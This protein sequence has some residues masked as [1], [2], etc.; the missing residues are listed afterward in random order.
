MNYHL[1]SLGW[2]L[3]HFCWQAGAIAVV[4]WLADA[5]LSKASSQTRY[6]LAL[7]AMLLMFL[8][9]VATFGYE[10][11][12]AHSKPF[13]SDAGSWAGPS[14]AFDPAS[15][16][17]RST[18]G[19][20]AEPIRLSQLLPWLDVAWSL[21]VACFSTRTIAGWGSLQR[22]RKQASVEAPEGVRVNFT[23][24]CHRLGIQRRVDLLIS[25][26][27]Q[28]PLAMGIVRAV[29]LV[30]ASTLMALSPEQL[31]AVL[32]HELAHIRR[33]D[34]VWNLAQT[35]IET[36]FFFHPA[37]WW[38]G[39]KV[40]HHRELCCDDLAVQSCGDAVL[41]ATALL[42]LEEQRS[43]QL[44]LAM[45][46]DGH[47]SVSGLRTRIARILGESMGNR[48]PH[49][50]APLPLAAIFSALTL[51]LLSAPPLL[52]G[53]PQNATMT[54]AAPALPPP[55]PVRPVPD[56]VVL[57]PTPR[58]AVAPPAARLAPLAA[59]GIQQSATA[60]SPAHKSDYIDEMRAAGY[61]ADIDKYVAMKVQGITPDYA[62]EMAKAGFGKPSADDLIA[63]KVQGVT[64]DY[65]AELHSAGIEPS[66]FG[67]LVAYRIFHVTPEFFAGM[68][69]AGFDSVP[70]SKLIALRV[71][72]VTPEYA[73]TVKQQY[74]NAT[75]DELVQLRIFH[76][77]DAF[78]AA[79]KRHGFTS[80]S[81]EKLVQLRI[82]GVLGDDEAG[83]K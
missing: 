70:P 44:N 36:L 8:G 56:P 55:T 15:F 48:G 65:V 63:M 80:L 50:P 73:K 71:H 9:A 69:A 57:P 19:S 53:L 24:L 45:A 49:E 81:I 78:L 42:R 31:E 14:A 59:L 51:L 38:L 2:T 28:G 61:D 34:Y 54:P 43:R 1:Q 68:K 39:H 5:A 25:E 30:P 20:A 17:G 67:D 60:D 62:R 58:I 12:H 52:A 3:L 74:P 7:G 77:D 21:G 40:R 82:S 47:R 11:T 66:S 41:Y 64:P 23:R 18:S 6:L 29:I 16:T 4:Y 26:H 33:A 27:I 32:A 79:A 75:L 35:T 22:L 37:V 83:T 13:L 76:I 72:G 46:L 10:E